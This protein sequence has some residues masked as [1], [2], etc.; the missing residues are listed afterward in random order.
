ML[1]RLEGV[2]VLHQAA[3][4]PSR[5]R[6]RVDRGEFHQ[7]FVRGRVSTYLIHQRTLSL[8][9]DLWLHSRIGIAIA[10]AWTEK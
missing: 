10:W 1:G 7:H 4:R 9:C 2:G 6:Y 3:A 8:T 5:E